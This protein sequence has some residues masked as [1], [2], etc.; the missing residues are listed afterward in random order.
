MLLSCS[1]DSSM[2]F[3]ITVT[4]VRYSMYGFV[5][6]HKKC[7]ITKVSDRPHKISQNHI[8]VRSHFCEDHNFVRSQNCEITITK[9]WGK[10]LSYYQCPNH[11]T[12]RVNKTAAWFCLSKKAQD[13]SKL[14]WQLPYYA[15][16]RLKRIAQFR[17]VIRWS[18]R[19]SHY[20]HLCGTSFT[21]SSQFR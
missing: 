14:W 19:W 12:K 17:K 7:D 6:P 10:H 18:A 2:G 21:W 9:L 5:L 15:Q 1:L 3:T 20:F 4:M 8:F 13:T 11:L 16:R